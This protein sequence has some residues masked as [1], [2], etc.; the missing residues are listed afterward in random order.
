EGH[1]HD[2]G[3]TSGRT[4]IRPCPG[5]EHE[6]DMTSRSATDSHATH[7]AGLL[8]GVS[9]YAIWGFFPLYFPLL[10]PASPLEILCE[11][12]VFS[13][14]FMAVLLTATR[15]WTRLVSVVRDVR[16]VLMLSAAAALIAVNWGT[17][18]WAVN[19]GNVV[20]ASLGYFVN[21]LVLVVLG[22]LVLGER[23]RRL[24]WTA[25]GIATAA[26][27][28]LTVGLGRLPWIALALALSF[29]GY[30]LIKKLAG[31]D[32]QSSLTVETAVA[33]PFALAYLAHLQL[34]GGLVL[35]HGPTSTT[36]LLACTGVVTAVPLLLFGGAANRIPLTT[37]GLLQYLTPSIQFVIGVWID[38]EAM[39]PARWA[40]FVIVWVALAVFSYDGL[41]E[42]RRGVRAA[43][44]GGIDEVEA[45][46]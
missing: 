3:A 16:I 1:L 15:G 30:G 11:R 26:V 31:V 38:G 34:T 14:V 36:V 4:S 8:L 45:P 32:P 12:F 44:V 37:M 19:N 42:S 17:Y 41:R 35:G 33:T 40:G 24:Q 43:A 20:E 22:V 9:A 23:L 6:V 2:S 25:V 18:I 28:V 7:R 13:L 5:P 27:V 39:S 10:D 21:P 46:V 29:A